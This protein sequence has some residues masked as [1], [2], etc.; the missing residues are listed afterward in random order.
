MGE[1][2]KKKLKEMIPFG[3]LE[4]LGD[5]F[6]AEM[7]KTPVNYYVAGKKTGAFISQSVQDIIAVSFPV[8]KG[9]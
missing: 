1:E 7:E 6:W 8:A 9:V 2:A 4:R 3:A 5:E